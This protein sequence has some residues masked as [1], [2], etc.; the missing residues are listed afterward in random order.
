MGDRQSSPN[1]WN[2]YAATSHHGLTSAP[3]L[4][5]RAA[6]TMNRNP[7]AISTS[8]SAILAGVLGCRLRRAS[9]VHS[10]ANSGAARTRTTGFTD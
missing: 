8:A 6:N 9:A 5:A 10:A 3:P 2:E 4:P 1:V 7:V